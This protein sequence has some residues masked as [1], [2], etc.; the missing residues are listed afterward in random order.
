MKKMLMVVLA[1]AVGIIIIIKHNLLHIVDTS[2]KGVIKHCIDIF[3]GTLAARIISKQKLIVV[4][5]LCTMTARV[6]VAGAI[7]VGVIPC[8]PMCLTCRSIYHTDL[9]IGIYSHN[10]P[11]FYH[12]IIYVL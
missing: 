3:G 5:A 2:I 10:I 12:V 4:F 8:K 7:S 9:I 6:S 1:V 11:H